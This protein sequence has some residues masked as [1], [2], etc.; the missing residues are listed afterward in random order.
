M[1]GDECVD[2]AIAFDVTERNP[3]TGG[4]DRCLIVAVVKFSAGR[5]ATRAVVDPDGIGLFI[6]DDKRIDMGIAIEVGEGDIGTVVIYWPQI[7]SA[8]E[9]VP[10]RA[11]LI[12]ALVDEN[13]VVIAKVGEKEIEVVIS[14]EVGHRYT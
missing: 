8:V 13:P 4:T 1:V 14:I 11:Q 7:L 3:P 5:K 2:I 6:V 10:F 12:T 9:E